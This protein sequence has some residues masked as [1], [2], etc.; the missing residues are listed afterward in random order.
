[1]TLSTWLRDYLYIPLGG[2]RKG[3]GRTY[4]NLMLTMVLG[5]LWHGA[6]W[7][8]VLW[9]FY[10]GLLLIAHRAWSQR[11]ERRAEPGPFADVALRIG[12]FQLVCLGWLFFRA[13]SFATIAAFL[14]PQVG[15]PF[16]GLILSDVIASGLVFGGIGA[17]AVLAWDLATWRQ[18][19]V[20]TPLEPGPAW[21]QAVA[22]VAIYLG[23][24]LLGRF[25]GN[26][27]IY[28]QF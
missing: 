3:S 7:N 23:V 18:G 17:L 1:M 14:G 21:T 9:G 8:F 16:D 20:E 2:N 11:R 13:H 22:C 10:Q 12:F 25:L 6:A 5:G 15:G 24:S 28:F 27:F 19:E 26:E 4:V